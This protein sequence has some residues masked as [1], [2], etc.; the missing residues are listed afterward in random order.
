MMDG[1]AGHPLTTFGA[2][3]NK[4][5]TKDHSVIILDFEGIRTH[6]DRIKRVL[7]SYQHVAAVKQDE[8]IFLVGQSA[9]G[10]AV[11]IAG[12]RIGEGG[13]L[14]GVIMLSPAMPR[15]IWFLTLTL[16]MTM[17]KRVTELLFGKNATSHLTE[18]EH[19]ALVSPIDKELGMQAVSNRPD[20]PLKEAR[21]LAF[22]PDQLGQ[23]PF[24]ILHVYGEKDQWIAARAQRKLC[25]ILARNGSQIESYGMPR[26][27]HVTLL[28]QDR[29]SVTDII[30]TWTR[31]RLAK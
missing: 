28:S 13:N 8:R 7:D 3:K 5:E 27:G 15:S 26:S 2:L 23:C 6:E 9:G 1:L 24:P 29:E 30:E 20:I 31:S 14:A 21:K 17:A 10:S 25:A 16:F 4:L 18:Q 19:L 12:E 22:Y 11:R